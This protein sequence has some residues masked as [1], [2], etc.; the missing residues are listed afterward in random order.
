MERAEKAKKQ[1]MV[2]II[3]AYNSPTSLQ[4][5]RGLQEKL[6]EYQKSSGQQ[7][8]IVV[9]KAGGQVAV[10]PELVQDL[11]ARADLLVPVSTAALQAALIASS[12]QPVVFSSVANPY[13]VRA[14][15]TAVDHDP[16]V[17][18]VCSTAPIRQVLALIHQ[19]L[20][21]ARK[22]G[23]LWTP[24]EINSEYYLEL[25]REA[26]SELGLEIIS[27]PIA[28]AGEIV[29]AVQALVRDRVEVL[30]PVSD[31]T[32][33]A[34]FQ[35]IGKLAA[36]NRLPLFAAFATGAELGACASMGFGFE[37]IGY[38][39]AELVIRIKNGESPSR[40]PFQ[41]IDRVRFFVNQEAAQNQGISLPE[42]VLKKA[43]RVIRA[44]GEDGEK[45]QP[46]AAARSEG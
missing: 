10:L 18:G 29:Q 44:Y 20:P 14:G 37:D 33:N 7:L 8:E 1:Y 25:M 41:Y 4:V 12:E 38:K 23:T 21:A 39:T 19:L 13:I 11:A 42:S 34:N 5:L 16:R 36:E 24:S 9:R 28:G 43:D 32:I 17:T 45:S 6:E 35:V 2:G 40:I 22:I 26:A 27:Q 30:F 15:R 46:A 31:N 3:L